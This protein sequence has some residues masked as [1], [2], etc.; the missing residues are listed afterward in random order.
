MNHTYL[1][2]RKHGNILVSV[3]N[4]QHGHAVILYRYLFYD[5][6]IENGTVV[7]IVVTSKAP[8]FLKQHARITAAQRGQLN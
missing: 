3:Q 2:L 5:F 1:E 4:P 8:E 7:K 6:S